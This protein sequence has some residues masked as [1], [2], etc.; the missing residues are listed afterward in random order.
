MPLHQSLVNIASMLKE[1]KEGQQ[2]SPTL[3]KRQP[4]TSQQK[5]AKHCGICSCNS[6]YTNECPQLQEDNTI[7][8]THNFFEAT[9]IPP[10][11]KQYYTQGWCNNQ[12]TRWNPLSSSKLSLVNL[13][14]TANHKTFKIQDTNL[15]ITVN[16]TLQRIL[17]RLVMMKPSVPSKGKIKR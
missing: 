7:A 9:T 11:N 6:H 14:H 1:I 13:T 17:L 10:Y 12:P 8:S 2:S 15:H 16:H 5:P 3:L 4:D